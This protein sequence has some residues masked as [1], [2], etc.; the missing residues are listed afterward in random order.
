MEENDSRVSELVG[1]AF[2][3]GL[4]GGVSDASEAALR[5]LF[6]LLAESHLLFRF[7]QGKSIVGSA[8]GEPKTIGDMLSQWV[9]DS[10]AYD[11]FG[12]AGGTDSAKAQ[13]TTA[14]SEG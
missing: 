12:L 9:K 5:E 3:S 8:P 4:F 14:G 2:E 1:V 11:V 7:L 13:A 10:P 6:G